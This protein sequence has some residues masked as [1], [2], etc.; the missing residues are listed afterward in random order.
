MVSASD[1]DDPFL[2]LKMGELWPLLVDDL[3][4]CWLLPN[5]PN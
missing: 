2:P 4:G 1:G 3:L 5:N